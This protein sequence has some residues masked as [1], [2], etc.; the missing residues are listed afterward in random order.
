M[1]RYFGIST[2]TLAKCDLPAK[3]DQ[4]TTTFSVTTSKITVVSFIGKITSMAINDSTSWKSL[5]VTFFLLLDEMASREDLLYFANKRNTIHIGKTECGPFFARDCHE[6]LSQRHNWEKTLTPCGRDRIYNSSLFNFTA[7]SLIL[8]Y[9][10]SNHFDDV[11]C[12]V[13]RNHRL[14]VFLSCSDAPISE[15]NHGK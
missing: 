2:N 3:F 7:S 5:K 6:Q 8:T 1:S 12:A 11:P 4:Q 14:W 15:P 13:M 9:I 10:S